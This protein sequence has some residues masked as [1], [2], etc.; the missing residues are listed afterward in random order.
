MTSPFVF[1]AHDRLSP[2]ELSAARLDGHLVELGEGYLLAD[3]VETVAMR[4]A[5]LAPLLREHHAASLLSAAWVHGA[6]DEPPARHTACRANGHRRSEMSHPRVV[7]LETTVDPADVV[8]YGDVRVTSAARTLADLARAAVSD[9]RGL[10]RA[11]RIA[12]QQMVSRALSSP[13]AAAESLKRSRRLPPGGRDALRF[14]AELED[15]LL[16]RAVVSD[17]APGQAE[18]TR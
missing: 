13:E 1:F 5:S 9:Q 11:A 10:T 8:V 16:P 14:L 4:A 17:G 6:I 15:G 2:A 7:V 18:V 3:A 12:A